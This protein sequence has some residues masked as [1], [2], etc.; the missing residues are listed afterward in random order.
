MHSMFRGTILL[1]ALTFS[2][3]C[4]GA[5]LT[6]PSEYPT[7]QAAISAAV[8]GDVV[9]IQ[10]GTYH[11]SVVLASG[12]SLV[13]ESTDSVILG[14][15]ASWATI[16]GHNSASGSIENL[17]VINDPGTTTTTTGLYLDNCGIDLRNVVVRGFGN[18]VF[19]RGA[20]N[21]TSGGY[22]PPPR[23]QTIEGSSFDG[24]QTGINFYGAQSAVVRNNSFTGN[25]G[26]GIYMKYSCNPEIAANIFDG[27]GVGI[28]VWEQSKPLIKNNSI[29]R[30]TT[31]IAHAW[32]SHSTIIGNIISENSW[33]GIYAVSYSS[34]RITNN[35]VSRNGGDGLWMFLNWATIENNTIVGNTGDGISAE[36]YA[37]ISPRNNIIAYNG[38]W[39]AFT[40]TYY[41]YSHGNIY[42][43]YN[44]IFGNGAG[45]LR[46]NAYDQVGNI[47]VD[48]L[49]RDMTSNNFQLYYGS[50]CIDAGDI[51]PAYNDPDGTR[52]DLGAY[53]G[54]FALPKDFTV[55]E[56]IQQIAAKV[57]TL[58]E[59]AFKNEPADRKAS[60]EDKFGEVIQLTVSGNE[61]TEPAARR[62]YYNDAILKLEND[63]LKKSDGFFGGNPKNDWITSYE[64][65]SQLYPIIVDMK[66]ELTVLL[67]SLK[68]NSGK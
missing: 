39:G 43:Y 5:T 55:V 10:A 11:E 51:A 57:M 4:F 47:Y 45:A 58:P 61:A 36:W 42:L 64:A 19:Y 38:G 23:T 52:N 22:L 24:N 12:V 54:P 20:Y 25:T 6:V 9:F 62:L 41:S 33:D 3:T 15:G 17:S 16:E 53:G 14:N 56:E 50:P 63:I 7:I 66:N 68:V 32:S 60:F 13:G 67:N 48:P 31:G 49:F 65:Q 28:Y 2:A 46:P 1:V 34:P 40:S 27:N 29:L 44:N 18:G 59:S 8:P 21:Y 37:S 35:I 26:S 30:N